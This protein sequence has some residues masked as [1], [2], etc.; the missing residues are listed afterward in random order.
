[1]LH[2][3]RDNNLLPEEVISNKNCMANNGTLC[4]T[5]F[6]NITWQG[7]PAVMASVDASNCYD[8]IA[9]AMAS[10]LFQALGVPTSAIYSMLGAIKECEVL[11][12]DRIWQL[13][14]HRGRRDKHKDTR[15]VSRQWSSS[16]TMGGD[17][18]LHH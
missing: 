3:T 5:L 8:M 10:L 16:C 12:S 11:I 18:H 13:Q 9:H 2:N 17:K 1:M 4:K 6:Y 7:V 14:D 15:D